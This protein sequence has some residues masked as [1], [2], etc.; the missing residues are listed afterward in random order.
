[1]KIG[2]LQNLVKDPKTDHY[3]FFCQFMDYLCDSNYQLYLKVLKK[4]GKWVDE[5]RKGHAI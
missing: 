3:V 1:M 5:A 2:E 4:I